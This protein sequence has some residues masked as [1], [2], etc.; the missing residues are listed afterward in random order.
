MEKW[1]K[2]MGRTDHTDIERSK[3]RLLS[4]IDKTTH[5]CWIWQG[6][7]A[8]KG[9]G[10]GKIG[11]GTTSWWAHRAFYHFF[12]GS[13]PQ[14]KQVCHNCDIPLCCNPAHLYIGTQQDNI[15]DQIR[16]GRNCRGVKS[17]HAKLNDNKIAGIRA[18]WITEKFSQTQ[19]AEMFGVKQQA[20]DKIVN[21]KKWR[22][23]P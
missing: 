13:I 20:I 12:K 14:G 10:Y 1:A 22:H 15:N 6:Y 17:H 8:T 5:G 21:Y 9:L 16:R 7:V 18:L 4:L 19:I 11:L 23:L 3:L 2:I